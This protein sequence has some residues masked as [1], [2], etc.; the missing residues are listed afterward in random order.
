M[1]SLNQATNLDNP[2]RF[3]SGHV[4]HYGSSTCHNSSPSRI[5]ILHAEPAMGLSSIATTDGHTKTRERNCHLPS[6]ETM[7]L[8]DMVGSSTIATVALRLVVR[9]DP[10]NR[11]SELDLSLLTQFTTS[12]Q[13]PTKATWLSLVAA[14]LTLEPAILG[15]IYFCGLVSLSCATNPAHYMAS[16][17]LSARSSSYCQTQATF[18]STFK[19][20]SRP[21]TTKPRHR[22]LGLLNLRRSAPSR[23][24]TTPPNLK[25]QTAQQYPPPHP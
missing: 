18:Q 10:L 14:I 4:R 3:D 5:P 7:D 11:H 21:T 1:D 23:S 22:D 24:S 6:S 9:S 15:I 12:I 16:I 2:S 19:T 20:H 8:V 25:L 17:R 13:T